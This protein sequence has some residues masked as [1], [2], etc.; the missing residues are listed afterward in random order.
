VSACTVNAQCTSGLTAVRLACEA[1]AAGAAEVVLAG[2]FEST[3]RA[4]V[5]LGG[6]P[7]AFAG[8]TR[9]AHAPPPFADPDMGPAADAVAERLGISRE[10][11]DEVALASYGRAVR[12]RQSGL[13]APLVVAVGGTTEDDLPRRL[14][15]PDR[16]RRY[17]PAFRDSGMVTV[18]NAAP[19]ADGAAVLVLAS[20]PG[21]GP[22]FRIR[23][24]ASAATDPSLPALAVVPAVEAALATAGLDAGSVDRWEVNEAF[25]VKVVALVRHFGVPLDRV[26]PNGGAIATGHPFG[27]SGAIILLHLQHELRR[28]GGRY[29]VAA[30]AGAGGLGEAVVLERV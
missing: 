14:P 10:A 21:A 11:Q 24:T 28:S 6:R 29:G 5:D 16:L 1:I 27:A 13:L 30:I 3:S 12:A 20:Q 18:G 17:P 25:A 8:A 22:C 4:D 7:G 9:V 26:N 19:F 23:A 15:S 2:G